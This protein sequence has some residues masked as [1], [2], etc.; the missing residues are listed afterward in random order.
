MTQTPPDLID[1]THR[2]ERAKEH[3]ET[4]RSRTKT[5]LERDPKPLDF[6]TEEQSGPGNAKQ[7]VLFAVI[8]EEPPRNLGAPVGDA[9]QNIRN[10][11]DYLIDELSPPKFRRRGR[12]GFP[13]YDDKCLFEVEGRRLIRGITGDA[14]TLIE[15]FQPYK[16][17]DPPSNDPLSVLRRLSNKDKHR[18]LLPVAAAVSDSNS[19]VS[20]DNA[21]IN[22]TGYA[23][24]PVKHDAEIL[25]FTA[26]PKDPSKNMQ[27]YPQSGLEVQLGEPGLF[28]SDGTPVT[29]EISDFLGYLWDHVSHTVIDMWFKYGYMPPEPTP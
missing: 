2:L 1:I 22:F 17:T 26:R 24:G 10:A 25:A 4:V 21:I 5:F 27:V 13:I 9:I 20:S 11:L 19:W 16:R 29:A 8:R 7:Y 14:L 23:P 3:I 6:R 28:Y 12:T 15:R 18:L